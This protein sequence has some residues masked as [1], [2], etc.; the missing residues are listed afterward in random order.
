MINIVLCVI[1]FLFGLM[2]QCMGTMGKDYRARKA[3]LLLLLCLFSFI[4]SISHIVKM[5]GLESYEKKCFEEG[6]FVG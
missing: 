3:N 4:L 1:F 5:R 2:E 6:G